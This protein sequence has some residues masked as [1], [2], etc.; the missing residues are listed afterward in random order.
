[1]T[2]N[3]THTVKSC[4]SNMLGRQRTAAGQIGVLAIVVVWAGAT[5]V[6]VVEPPEV[7]FDWTSDARVLNTT[8][9]P[10]T[11]T[12]LTT[13][14]ATSSTTTSTTAVSSATTTETSSQCPAVR[15]CQDDQQCR[16]C[17]A[18]VH[19]FADSPLSARVATIRETQFLAALV[20]TSSCFPNATNATLFSA[21]LSE[22]NQDG[23]CM[24]RAGMQTGSCQMSEYRCFVNSQ[25]RGCLVAL[26][27]DRHMTSYT[28]ETAECVNANVAGLLPTNGACTAFPLCSFSK[29][30]CINSSRCLG[31]L[32][33][34]ESGN[35]LA[36]AADCSNGTDAVLINRVASACLSKSSIGCD[37]EESRCHEDPLCR[38]CLLSM[39]GGASTSGIIAGASS[40]ACTELR[41]NTNHSASTAL[42]LGIFRACPL[43]TYTACETAT[44][45]C[46]MISDECLACIN[47][48]ADTASIDCPSFLSNTGFAVTEACAACPDTVHIINSVV[49]ATVVV[50][51]LSFLVCMV[52]FCQIA[53]LGY[54]STFRDR[55]IGGLMLANAI[56]SSSN[57]IPCNLQESS[58]EL[59]GQLVLSLSMIRIGRALWFFGKVSPLFCLLSR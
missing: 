26:Y 38:R 59:C 53:S 46:V 56:Y 23:A 42:L 57:C 6:S 33:S 32:T 13:G 44:A 36:A 55:L 40:T 43:T 34:L 54:S 15:R 19:A 25:C 5:E 12:A 58:V 20:R 2:E 21:V 16:T 14:T 39:G 24:Y 4:S 11:T 47:G 52:V 41:S 18:A 27:A 30:Q 35:A 22:T 8:S 37:F 3:Q 28:L 10:N 1:M 9:P 17:L 29:R 45:A 7:V 49:T 50:G 31:C 48:S 51:G